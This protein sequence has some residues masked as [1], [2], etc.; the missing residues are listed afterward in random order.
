MPRVKYIKSDIE[1]LARIMRAE[2][3]GEGSTGMMLVGNVV[4]NR[5]RAKCGPFKNVSTIRQVIY[6][7]SQFE[8]V[9]TRL[10]NQHPTENEKRLAKACL[11]YWTKW[12][13]KNSL[14]FKNPGKNVKC[15]QTFFG[16][17]IGRYK[18]HC[19]YAK[20]PKLKNCNF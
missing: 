9:G 17:L 8:G 15:P 16:P 7:K 12:P 11:D 5:A 1:L 6:Q 2:A 13:A 3:V 18:N 20:D 4:V 10:F 14:Y 19:F